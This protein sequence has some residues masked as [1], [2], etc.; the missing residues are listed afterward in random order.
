MLVRHEITIPPENSN[1]ALAALV[2]YRPWH[3]QQGRRLRE[4]WWESSMV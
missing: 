3:L 1:A 4:A 2:S